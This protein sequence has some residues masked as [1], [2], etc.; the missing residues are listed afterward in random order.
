ML[1]T[2]KSMGKAPVM[3]VDSNQPSETLVFKVTY[4]KRFR[5]KTLKT[6]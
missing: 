4:G 3:A 2:L 1:N 6:I 5:D